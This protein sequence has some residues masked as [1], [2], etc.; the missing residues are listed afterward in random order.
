MGHHDDELEHTTAA[1]DEP[2]VKDGT[3]P[4]QTVVSDDI[5]QEMLRED[6]AER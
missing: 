1:A 4:N 3:D 5:D 2:A 6:I